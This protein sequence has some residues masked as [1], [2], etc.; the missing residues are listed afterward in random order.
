MPS[1][2]RHPRNTAF[3]DPKVAAAFVLGH[4]ERGMQRDFRSLSVETPGGMPPLHQIDVNPITALTR[5]GKDS[6]FRL[7]TTDDVEIAF[8]FLRQLGHAFHVDDAVNA[9]PAPQISP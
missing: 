3:L 5:A 4:P 2:V 1:D 6:P 7:G 9:M 8:Q